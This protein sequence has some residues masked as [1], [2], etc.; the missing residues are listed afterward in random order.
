M[1]PPPALPPLTARN[2]MAL[3]SRH[4]AALLGVHVHH[5]VFLPACL[6]A[7]RMLHAHAARAVITEV[8][9]DLP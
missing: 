4:T 3:A 9:H 7:C 2:K 8:F 1:Q 5:V 6:P